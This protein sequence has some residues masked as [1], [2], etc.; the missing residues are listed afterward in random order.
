MLY[1]SIQ[2]ISKYSK[3][4]KHLILIDYYSISQIKEIKK[5]VIN[6]LLYQILVS[7]IHGKILKN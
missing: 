4:V 2:K 6:M 5:I 3:I 7:T 1:L